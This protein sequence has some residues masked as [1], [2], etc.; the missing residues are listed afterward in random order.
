[1]YITLLPTADTD[2][3]EHADE[4]ERTDGNEADHVRVRRHL[5]PLHGK[6]LIAHFCDVY[7]GRLVDRDSSHVHND[8]LN[9]QGIFKENLT[10]GV[11][12]GAN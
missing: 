1:M 6:T 7:S 11:A 9:I 2:V 4:G 5:S 12:D 3:A 8:M 10:G